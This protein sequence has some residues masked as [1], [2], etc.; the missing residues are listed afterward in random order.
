TGKYLNRENE[1]TQGVSSTKIYTQMN[2]P[3][4]TTINWFASNNGGATWEA[5]SILTTRKIDEE[6]TEYTLTRTFSDPN[7]NRVRYKAEMTGNN[8]AYPRIH[9]LGATLSWSEGR[10]ED[11]QSVV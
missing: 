9:T 7:G 10:H 5:M 11:R 2:I 6:W 4:G 3:S 1:L 8:L